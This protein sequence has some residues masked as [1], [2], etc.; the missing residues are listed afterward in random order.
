[1]RVISNALVS[2]NT[3]KNL[4][5][6]GKG[7]SVG[8]GKLM[9]LL[10]DA[11]NGEI[12]LEAALKG[13]F[14]GKGKFL[15]N[16][17]GNVE[18]PLPA[19]TSLPE[20]GNV[21]IK[22]SLQNDTISATFVLEDT[23]Q[24]GQVQLKAEDA[25]SQLKQIGLPQT[26]QNIKAV[27]LLN[28]Y[29]IEPSADRI[30]QLAEGSFLA[31]KANEISE[32]EGFE[33]SVM[34]K[35]QKVDMSKTLKTLVVQWLSQHTEA[36]E[37]ASVTVS[38]PEQGK[39]EVASKVTLPETGALVEGKEA[40]KA[41]TLP[42]ETILGG[43]AKNIP[44][45]ESDP[46]ELSSKGK[47]KE[48]IRGEMVQTLSDLKTL[49]KNLSPKQLLP[50]IASDTKL[51]L[52]NLLLSEQV[53]SGSKNIGQLKDVLVSK[54]SQ[55]FS[56]LEPSKALIQ[57]IVTWVEEDPAALTFKN[58]LEQLES[59]IAK[60]SPEAAMEMKDS[61]EQINKAMDFVN[62]M[63]SQMM[64][65]H[66]PMQLGDHDTQV[67]LYMNKRKGRQNQDEFRMFLALNTNAIG[68]VQVLITDQKNGVELQ[69]KLETDAL[70]EAFENESE[71]FLKILEI[72]SEKPI[73]LKFTTHS[74]EPAILEAFKA[75]KEDQTTSID[76]RV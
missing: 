73:R 12:V 76:M 42:V 47:E 29:H 21:T 60:H 51:N 41:K 5:A 67:E 7:N 13:I 8:T 16:N 25:I 9:E 36:N 37:R 69:F 27:Q 32:G 38:A 49:L 18:I 26:E 11:Q 55:V 75:L 68:Q 24:A 52:E 33:S 71:D 45:Q 50:L 65:F 28:E 34:S 3:E 6:E 62:Q 61:F 40:G 19:N 1:M 56:T 58:Q 14:E 57:E 30:K 35:D 74:K 17:V 20:S 44:M 72:Y 43:E 15:L 39:S 22:F 70:K 2:L 10:R 64:A 63:Q 59:I 46:L 53:F 48:Q 66:I 23:A 31:S 54:L 4:S